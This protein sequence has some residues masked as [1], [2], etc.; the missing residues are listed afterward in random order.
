MKSVFNFLLLSAAV[1][2]Q[3]QGAEIIN[4]KN[5]RKIKQKKLALL[6]N[7]HYNFIGI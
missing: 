1:V 4:Q 7:C 3:L 6:L 5:M 2:L